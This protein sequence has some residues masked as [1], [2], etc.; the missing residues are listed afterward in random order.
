VWSDDDEA[1]LHH[2]YERALA[3]H[4]A[5]EVQRLQ[6]EVRRLEREIDRLEDQLRRAISAAAKEE[7]VK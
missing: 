1:E 7:E 3:E 2:S 5:E 6:A 4:Y